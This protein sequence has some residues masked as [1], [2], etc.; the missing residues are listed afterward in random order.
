[1]GVR[2]ILVSQHNRAVDH[3]VFIGS[4]GGYM[5]E[6]PF[7]NTAFAPA[8]QSCRHGN[9]IELF[10]QTDAYPRLTRRHDLPTREKTLYP[11]PLTIVQ[12]ISTHLHISPKNRKKHHRLYGGAR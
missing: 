3:L 11:L 8:A 10:L 2:T 7:N 1:M 4:I 6:N 9:N 5:A 12:T